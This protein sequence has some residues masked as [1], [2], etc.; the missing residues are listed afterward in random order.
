MSAL[1]KFAAWV[2]AAA[3]LSI[4]CQ[5][6]AFGQDI[7]VAT[8]TPAEAPAQL[9][10]EAAQVTGNPLTLT[11]AEQHS[12]HIFPTVES[13]AVTNTSGGPLIYHSGGSIMPLLNIYAIFWKPATLQNGNP[14]VMSAAYRTIQGNLLEDYVGHGIHNNNTQYYQ[15]ISGVTTYVSGLLF[16]TAGTGS[17]AAAYVD[18]GSYPA[19]GCTDAATPG[20]CITDAQLQTELQR[21]MTLKGWT[22]GLDK[23][24]VIY[25]AQG[26][27][28]CFKSDS[29]TCAY[30]PN[31]GGSAYC[32]YHGAIGSSPA[33][34]IIYA[35]IPY[36]NPGHCQVPGTPSPNANPSA[37]TA[38]T[39]V[40]HELTEA[41]TDP[42]LNAWFDSSGNEIGD[43]CAY[44]YATNSYDG[45]L[46]N[47]SWNG[48]FYE[49]QQEYDN[50]AGGC[51]QVGP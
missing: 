37:D 48:R 11:D 3:A 51:V 34:A 38:T 10:S 35:N 18:T 46:A 45:A 40:S 43:L 42:L 5:A 36:G 30:K 12:I 44:N 22:G 25:T 32:A 2:T 13:S 28:S 49:L 9:L 14:A 8:A 41:V 21:V 20:N 27:G 31:T 17:E 7:N 4:V 23:I 16:S 39:A 26:E 1:T 24:F 15:I 33:T 29:V 50:H 6:T 19:S 47:Q